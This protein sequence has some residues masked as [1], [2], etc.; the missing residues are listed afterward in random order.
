MPLPTTR[1][2]A[3]A[4]LVLALTTGRAAEP[5]PAAKIDLAKEVSEL[6]GVLKQQLAEQRSLNTKVLDSVTKQDKFLNDFKELR[7][8]IAA[9]KRDV[10]EVRVKPATNGTDLQSLRDEIAGLRRQIEDM[11]RSVTTSSAKVTQSAKLRFVNRY[12][13]DMTVIANGSTF[14]VPAG[15]EREV[16]VAPG[17]VTYQVVGYQSVAKLNTLS[18]NQMLTVTLKPTF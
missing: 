10:T 9:L 3:A 13:A 7:E 14:V 11:R 4:A 8:E 17:T 1:Y 12:V 5:E 2:A 18:D 16:S 6:V 15:E